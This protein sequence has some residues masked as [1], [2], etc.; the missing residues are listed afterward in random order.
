MQE[1]APTCYILLGDVGFVNEGLV[2]H[3]RFA[4]LL[5]WLVDRAFN[6]LG[7]VG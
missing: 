2:F 7:A 5:H 3:G 6:G 1:G 4:G